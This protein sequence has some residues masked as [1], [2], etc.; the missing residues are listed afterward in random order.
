MEELINLIEKYFDPNKKKPVSYFFEQILCGKI[1]CQDILDKYNIHKIEPMKYG[2]QNYGGFISDKLVLKVD[3]H[4]LINDD[5]L[6]KGIQHSYAEGANISNI[7]EVIKKKNKY[8]VFESKVSGKDINLYSASHNEQDICCDF[9]DASDS[10]IIK[11][12]KD[13]K[14][15][16]K[17]NVLFEYIGDNMKYDPDKGFGLFDFER[18]KGEPNCFY[19]IYNLKKEQLLKAIELGR[20]NILIQEAEEFFDR[21]YCLYNKYKKYSIGEINAELYSITSA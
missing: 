9:I 4:S 2:G 3:M 16:N 8:Y 7:I 20:A 10:H 17:N 6:I 13:L 14:I 18:I 11:L 21:V 19:S 5:L 1:E 12:I 15:L